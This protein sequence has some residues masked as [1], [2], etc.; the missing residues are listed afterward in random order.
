MAD[1]FCRQCGAPLAEGARFCKYCMTP[2]GAE[3]KES[4]SGTMES[5][6]EPG[7]TV[8]GKVDLRKAGHGSSAGFGA[9]NAVRGNAADGMGGS[10][11]T[12]GMQRNPYKIYGVLAYF[13][14]GVLVPILFKMDVRFVRFHVN[15]GLVLFLAEALLSLVYGFV[16]GIPILAMVVSISRLL[17]VAFMVLGMV[18]AVRGSEKPLPLV[19]KIHLVRESS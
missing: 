17:C 11:G 9:G 15:Q 14:I 10:G 16:G 3:S 18:S 5:G 19:G 2:A 12:A 4:G 13:S 8:T 7:G 1:K 6:A